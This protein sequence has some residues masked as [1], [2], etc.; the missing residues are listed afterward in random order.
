MIIQRAADKNKHQTHI[1][2]FLERGSDERQYGAPGIEL[3]VVTLSRSRFGKF[4]EYHTSLDDLN[5][6]SAAGLHNSV[7]AIANMLITLENNFHYTINCL[8]EPQL[9]KRGLYPT[10]STV[11]S[12]KT[13]RQLMNFITYCDGTN[14]LL[15]ICEIIGATPFDLAESIQQLKNENLLSIK[16]NQ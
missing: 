10:L 1:Y 16:D 3:P 8:G 6:I 9:G 7:K 13:I 5:F 11:E 14:D 2:S 12:G 15:D 4:K